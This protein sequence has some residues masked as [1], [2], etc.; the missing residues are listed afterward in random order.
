MTEWFPS[1]EWLGA[2]RE[3]LNDNDVYRE[4]SEGWGIE[5]DGDFLFVVEDLPL[6]ERTVGD[7][8]TELVA[9]FDEAV[10]STTDEAFGELLLAMP[11]PFAARFA[12][13]GDDRE[14]FLE[15]VH[16]TV[17]DD[18]PDE[19]WDDLRDLLSDELENLL[20]QLERYVE[21]GTAYA[22]LELSDGECHDASLLPEPDAQDPG[23]RLTGPYDVWCDLIEGADVVEAV[24]S[25]AMA[26]DGSVT[27]ILKYDEA[28]AAMGDTAELTPANYLLSPTGT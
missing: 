14:A 12:E 2:Y 23:F 25:Q 24:M 8:P 16:E 7:L 15:T 27:T 18:A 4:A 28:A 5:F 6:D 11:D 20:D 3:N 19:L 13:R 22:Y 10:K 21:D 9:P 1:E 17:L 26:L